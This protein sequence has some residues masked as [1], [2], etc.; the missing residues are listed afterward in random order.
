MPSQQFN[1]AAVAV[2]VAGYFELKSTQR[3]YVWPFVCSDDSTVVLNVKERAE[4]GKKT[5]SAR[6]RRCLASDSI[7]YDGLNF[8]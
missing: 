1:E 5:V 3:L 6:R 7:Y 4:V 2:A 8:C